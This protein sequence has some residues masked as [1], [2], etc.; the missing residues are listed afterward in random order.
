MR[1]YHDVIAV[2]VRDNFDYEIL[3]VGLIPFFDAEKGKTVWLDTFDKN[4][5]DKF[6]K[7]S[8][9]YDNKLKKMFNSLGIDY[10]TITCGKSFI[11]DLIVFFKKRERRLLRG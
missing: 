3:P 10:I 8:S 7:E 4:T 5:I 1:H 6:K 2:I 11:N 9:N